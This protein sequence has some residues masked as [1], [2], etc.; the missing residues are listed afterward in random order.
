MSIDSIV[1]AIFIFYL[2]TF[3]L[4]HYR[5][6]RKKIGAKKFWRFKTFA[7]LILIFVFIV[8][9]VLYVNVSEEKKFDDPKKF[10]EYGI[11][12]GSNQTIIKGC[13]LLI[14]EN[15]NDIDAHFL[16]AKTLFDYGTNQQINNYISLLYS[17]TKSDQI[18]SKN[19]GFLMLCY[20]DYYSSYKYDFDYLSFVS[21]KEIKYYNFLIG[22][23]EKEKSEFDLAVNSFKTEINNNG[24]LKGSTQFLY[25]IYDQN[26]DWENILSL[27]YDENLNEFLSRS[28]KK[29]VS[30]KN[31]DFLNYSVQIIGRTLDQ[32]TFLSAITAFLISFLWLN[33]LRRFD[34]YESE[35]WLNLFAVFTLGAGFT[36]F[37]YP[38]GDFIEHFFQLYF[39]GNDFINDFFYCS[40]VI[41]GVE[42]LVKIIPFLLVLK[43]FKFIDEPYDYILYA[44]VSAL[45]FAF[46]ENILY[47]KEYQFHVIFIRTVYAVVGHMFWASIVAY[48]FIKIDFGGKNRYSSLH[49]L[50]GSFVIASVGHGVYD[51]LLFYNLGMLNTMFFFL[52]LIAFM[53][54]INNS[55]N[56]SNFYNY[57][58]S[59]RREKMAFQLIIGLI[60]V[61]MFQYFIIGINNG[62][63][64]ANE[65]AIKN[66]PNGLMIITFLAILFSSINVKRGEWKA[67]SVFSFIPYF[68]LNGLRT[69]FYD[70]K[71]NGLKLR[72]FTNKTNPFLSSQLPVIG[73]V[74]KELNISNENGW[75]LVEFQKPI[76]VRN[77]LALRAVIR[78]VKSN[79][80]LRQDKI[81]IDFLMI[82]NSDV[83]NKKKVVKDDFFAIDRVYTICLS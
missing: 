11:E 79:A 37:V 74:V 78:P 30:F 80:T 36:F 20:L 29:K 64:Y 24:Y 76:T 55:L 68:T 83:L 57:E 62:S 7:D 27:V 34:I 44:S 3:V 47:F 69:F 6:A 18:R 75:Y 19:I 67:I 46:M 51:L 33:F 35:A 60:G 82:P 15:E 13:D 66:L 39:S 32:F 58:I 38:I 26:N 16:M 17:M 23:K 28:V 63:S 9:F 40:I 22:L 42:E 71:Q 70:K 77:Y 5:V 8:G 25:A 73:V 1:I 56:I 54:M 50:I 10:V 59:L 4:S 31:K 43:F 61:Y 45:G 12:N 48:S 65:M 14:D 21:N 49:V 2:F 53:F 81:K 41:G 72:F 52:S